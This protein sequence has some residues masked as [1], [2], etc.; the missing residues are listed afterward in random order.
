M[1]CIQGHNVS[2]YTCDLE[3]LGSLFIQVECIHS[4]VWSLCPKSRIKCELMEDKLS[5]LYQTV[6]ASLIMG[7]DHAPRKDTVTS[8]GKLKGNRCC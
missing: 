4:F 3:T 1:N 7:S 6:S 8:I 5:D 2:L